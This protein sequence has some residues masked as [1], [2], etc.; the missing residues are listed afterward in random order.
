M[1]AIK[2]TNGNIILRQRCEIL[3]TID[4][5][6]W[7]QAS[8]GKNLRMSQRLNASIRQ[9]MVMILTEPIW[10]VMNSSLYEYEP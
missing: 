2:E 5:R 8:V 1:A 10:L 7:T 9:P 6:Y 3:K 4:G